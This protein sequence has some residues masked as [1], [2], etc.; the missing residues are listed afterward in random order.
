MQQ[1]PR[2]LKLPQPQQLET[3]TVESATVEIG[4]EPDIAEKASE[5]PEMEEK[6]QAS[7]NTPESTTESETGKPALQLI[8]HTKINEANEIEPEEAPRQPPCREDRR[9]CK[10][11]KAEEE[12][13]DKACVGTKWRSQDKSQSWWFD[14]EDMSLS[15]RLGS[16]DILEPRKYALQRLKVAERPK[17][18]IQT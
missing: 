4:S 12:S 5:E 10:G 11:R 6:N 3:L 15:P 18:T 1:P 17:W 8:P 13:N 2:L 14:Q 16:I 7:V 9:V